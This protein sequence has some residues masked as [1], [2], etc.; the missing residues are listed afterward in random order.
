MQGTGGRGGG[1]DPPVP[2][3]LKLVMVNYKSYLDR[4]R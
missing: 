3:P 4:T 2:P 1:L